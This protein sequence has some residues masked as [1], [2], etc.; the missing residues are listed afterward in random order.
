MTTA[1]ISDI[2][3]GTNTGEDLLRRP[4]ALDALLGT[5]EDADELVLLGDLLELR[6]APVAEVLAAARPVLEALGRSR[7]GRRVTI[8]P[9]NHDHHLGAWLIDRTRANGDGP[10]LAVDTVSPPPAGGPAAAVARALGGEVRLAY[11]GRW[12]RGDVYATHGHYLD[13]HNTVPTMERVVIGLVAR[14][15]GGLPAGRLE[16]ADYEAA[17]GPVYGL[18]YALAQASPAGRRLVSGRASV[19]A[20]HALG[21]SGGRRSIRT[22]VLGDVLFPA[23]IA[24]LNRAGLGPLRSD[25]TALELRRGALRAM[26]QVLERLGVDAR[27][28]LFGHTHRAGPFD[29]ETDF[30]LSS[31]TQLLNTGSWVVEPTFLG[32]RPRESPYFPGTCVIVPDDGPPRLERLLV[33]IP[34]ATG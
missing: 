22:R 7:A 25:L 26:G 23:A 31:G 5:L 17:L 30:T 4:A 19:R 32:E 2:H 13:A 1:V 10:A 21:G 24:T 20:W 34:P 29:G 8:V 9:G 28:V 11:P 14:A 15:I 12:L 33:G 3:L 6:E 18:Q 27:Y 16:P